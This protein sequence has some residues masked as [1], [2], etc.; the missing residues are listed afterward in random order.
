MS[1]RKC[2]LFLTHWANSL[3][4]AE[5]S[6]L[7][8][9]PET[10]RRATVHLCTSE[11]GKFIDLLKEQN[12]SVHVIPC[13]DRLLQFKRYHFL[14]S[15]IFFS[16]SLPGYIGYVYRVHRLIARIRPDCIHANVPKSHV[17][18]FLLLLM[19]FRHKAIIHF[20]E[21]FPRCSSTYLLYALL[22]SFFPVR[23][24][25]ISQ[26][27]KNALP[28]YLQKKTTIIYNG[29]AIPRE[30]PPLLPTPPV[31]FLYFG[32]I[33]PW[34]GCHYL[35]EAFNELLRNVPPDT[36]RLTISGPTFYWD[37]GYREKIR[38]LIEMHHLRHVIDFNIGSDN[39]QGVYRQHHVVCMMSDN[40]PF[41]RVAAEAQ[42]CSL[43]VIAFESGGLQEII[44]HQKT[45]LLIRNRT[46]TS[47]AAA[48]QYFIENRSSID[49]MGR[50]GRKRA[51]TYFNNT[52]QIPKIAEMILS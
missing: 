41:G 12:I 29:V 30:S 18:L 38:E 8:L 34:K 23:I 21:I 9:I 19:G 15:I 45:G 44:I 20:R 11:N 22:F 13:T 7:D 28:R 26:A 5:Y 27:V 4:G 25:A 40:E 52:V 17:T 10:A 42:A 47:C 35:V 50:E 36:A 49:I 37:L 43:P 48:M 46:L 33:V 14:K 16:L 51:A 31:R 39:P 3:G 2:V 24:L 1:G 32:R 6:L